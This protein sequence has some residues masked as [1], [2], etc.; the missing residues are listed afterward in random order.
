MPIKSQDF[1]PGDTLAGNIG[2]NDV[3]YVT[4]LAEKGVPIELVVTTN[5]SPLAPRLSVHPMLDDGQNQLGA[6]I[7][8]WDVVG[9]TAVKWKPKTSGSWRSARKAWTAR[10]ASSRSKPDCSA[11]TPPTRS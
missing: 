3:D 2:S 5:P 4:A 11:P 10:P 9:T 1:T 8:A 6:E 7:D